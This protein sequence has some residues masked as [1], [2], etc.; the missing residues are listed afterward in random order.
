MISCFLLVGKERMKSSRERIRAL[1]A[2]DEPETAARIERILAVNGYRNTQTTSKVRSFRELEGYD[3]VIMDIMWPKDARPEH[4]SSEYFGLST[5]HYLKEKSPDCKIALMSKHLF[6]LEYLGEIQRADAYFRSD[7]DGGYVVRI[8]DDLCRGVGR[9][10][11]E[12]VGCTI[13]ERLELVEKVLLDGRS[14]LFGLK[15]KEYDEV[16]GEIEALQ[17]LA[18]GEELDHERLLARIDAVCSGFQNVDNILSLMLSMKR[19]ALE[20]R[21]GQDSGNDREENYDVFLCYNR[22][23]ESAVEKIAIELK[24]RG[25]KTWFDKW[26]MPPAK[27]WQVELGRQIERVRAAAVCVGSGNLGPWQNLET[28]AILKRAAVGSCALIPVVLRGVEGKPRFPFPLGEFHYVDFRRKEPDPMEQL[29]WGI[30]GKKSR[31]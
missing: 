17:L 29:I 13:S 18:R 16:M 30:T 14:D 25:I 23:D 11:L 2:D 22:K 15:E 24:K 3:I 5:L 27:I 7:S 31:Q 10:P 12:G 26:E 28:R 20:M 1:V 9:R 8:I 4:E 21:E 6:D 19:M